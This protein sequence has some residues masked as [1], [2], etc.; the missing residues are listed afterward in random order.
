VGIPSQDPD[1]ALAGAQR[2]DGRSIVMAGRSAARGFASR[3]CR[4]RGGFP[5][6]GRSAEDQRR[7]DGDGHKATRSTGL[8]ISRSFCN[9]SPRRNG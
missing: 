2:P 3:R 6:R 9:S 5:M 1:L 8:A 7:R 4:I